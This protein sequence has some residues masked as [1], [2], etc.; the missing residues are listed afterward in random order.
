MDATLSAREGN[1]RKSEKEQRRT[2]LALNFKNK[3]YIER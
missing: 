1:V 3:S 2:K